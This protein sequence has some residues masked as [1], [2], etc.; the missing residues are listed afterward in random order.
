[1]RNALC[2]MVDWMKINHKSTSSLVPLRASW[3]IASLVIKSIDIILRHTFF[4]V[5]VLYS[6]F[7]IFNFLQSHHCLSPGSWVAGFKFPIPFFDQ[8]AK[9]VAQKFCESTLLL[10]IPL[11]WRV[12]CCY[13]PLCV[14]ALIHAIILCHVTINGKEKHKR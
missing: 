8:N 2:T 11:R 1:M 10:T 3:K 12:Q 6:L 9:V 7:S 5:H 14:N 4:S 13:A